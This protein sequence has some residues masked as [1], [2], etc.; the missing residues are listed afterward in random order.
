MHI[1]KYMG[2]INLAVHGK[3]CCQVPAAGKFFQMRKQVL[4]A[5]FLAGDPLLKH[6]STSDVITLQLFNIKPNIILLRGL[7][8][9]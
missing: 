4:Q 5:A 8:G 9:R 2:L 6:N 1:Q 7:M 3:G